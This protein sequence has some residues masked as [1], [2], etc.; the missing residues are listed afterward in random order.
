[1]RDAGANRIVGDLE[2][3]LRSR[4]RR[5]LETP[6]ARGRFA[7]VQTFF[8][9]G[10]S[11]DAANRRRIAAAEALGK[12]GGNQFWSLPHGEPEWVHVPAGEFTM[13]DGPELHRLVLPA[14]DI[15]RVPITNAQ[16]QI[17]VQA[18]EHDP[19][20]DW[21]GQRAPRGKEAHPVVNVSWHD[22][23]AY[24]RWLSS[25][26]GKDITLPS[27]AE[28]EKAARGSED[29]RAYPWG[30]AFDATRCNVAESGFGGTT[31]VGIFASGASPFGCMDMAGN[32]WEWTRSLIGRWDQNDKEERIK[33][34][35]GYPYQ[36]TDGRE[37]FLAG[38]EWL[39]VL[40]GG[41]FLN[42]Q[43]LARCAYRFSNPPDSRNNGIGFRVVVRSAPVP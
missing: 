9:R 3:E 22:A 29:A 38:D 37:S 26:A 1:V 13:G 11:A 32:M 27:E 17:F 35:F 30:D 5:E 6:V 42:D 41:S 21:N 18:E 23:M 19:P 4:L 31:P 43:D 36:P 10:M 28:W 24:C 7:S 34:V 14:F 16:Y 33:D 20:G 40:R 39:R 15:A 12:I 8:V 25:V 2:A